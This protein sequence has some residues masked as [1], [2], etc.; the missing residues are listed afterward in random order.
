MS[1]VYSDNVSYIL[2]CLWEDKASETKKGSK[3]VLEAARDE[4]KTVTDIQVSSSQGASDDT[5]HVCDPGFMTF[6]KTCTVNVSDVILVIKRNDVD[7]SARDIVKTVD[8]YVFLLSSLKKLQQELLDLTREILS[9]RQK[10][11]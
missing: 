7:L 2:C 11:V 10:S 1:F 5:V 8:S 9:Y 6:V 4:V 3:H